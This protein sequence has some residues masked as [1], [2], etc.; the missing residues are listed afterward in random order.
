MPINLVIG[1]LLPI[2]LIGQ[3]DL[4]LI[5]KSNH[6]GLISQAV[7]TSLVRYRDGSTYIWCNGGELIGNLVLAD[8]LSL[9]I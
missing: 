3:L 1:R 4:G 7:L 9:P 5:T 8:L 6:Q 2:S